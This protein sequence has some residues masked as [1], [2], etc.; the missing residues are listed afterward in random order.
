MGAS[1]WEC[2]RVYG[3]KP[4]S[5]PGTLT[6]FCIQTEL[7]K[8]IFNHFFLM[9]SSGTESPQVQFIRSFVQGYEKKDVSHLVKHWHRDLRRITYPQSL[10]LPEE[11]REEWLQRITELISLWT[12][13]EVDRGQVLFILLPAKSL[14]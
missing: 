9:S 8:S 14:R 10:G 6:A 7:N 11:T 1:E 2:L 5:V 3:I 13:S 4:G 12:S